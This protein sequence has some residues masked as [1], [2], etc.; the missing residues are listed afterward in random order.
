MWAAFL[1]GT[2]FAGCCSADP[3][4]R[5]AF[6]F[7]WKIFRRP[8]S[9]DAERRGLEVGSG[10]GDLGKTNGRA[11]LLAVAALHRADLNDARSGFSILHFH[12][13]EF[14]RQAKGAHAPH[15]RTRTTVRFLERTGNANVSS[16]RFHRVLRGDAPR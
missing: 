14:F 2:R 13:S 3:F 9:T 12:L 10:S 8:F 7:F 11:A 5:F 4:F 15:L 6:L 16:I 1:R